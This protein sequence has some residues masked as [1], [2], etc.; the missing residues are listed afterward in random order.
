M[1]SRSKSLQCRRQILQCCCE[2]SIIAASL[3]ESGSNVFT[4]RSVGALLL[5]Q[6]AV[7]TLVGVG[8]AGTLPALNRVAW[9]DGQVADIRRITGVAPDAPDSNAELSQRFQRLP[10]FASLNGNP[11]A[12]ALAAQRIEVLRCVPAAA[13]ARRGGA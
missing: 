2:S 4:E 12:I 8:V 5:V 11:R 3:Y 13:S 10:I 1:P 9:C 7:P 6:Q